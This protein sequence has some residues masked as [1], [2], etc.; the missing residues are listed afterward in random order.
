[1]PLITGFDTR[2]LTKEHAIV[3]PLI[4]LVSLCLFYFIIKCRFIL[5]CYEGDFLASG[6]EDKSI[7]L[8]DVNRM[9]R[10]GTAKDV[11]K[12]GDFFCFL[13]I[14]E[15]FICEAFSFSCFPFPFLVK[16]LHRVTL[17]HQQLN[18]SFDQCTITHR[19][20]SNT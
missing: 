7:K 5:N 12:D 9:H 15:I 10:Y 1:M 18:Q 4:L 16:F 8:I 6:S 17:T 14:V 19:Y 13:A 11:S 20:D 2:R 3:Q